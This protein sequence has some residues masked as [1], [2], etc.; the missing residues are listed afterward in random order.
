MHTKHE[1]NFVNTVKIQKAMVMISLRL[2]RIKWYFGETGDK[3]YKRYG[4]TFIRY[5]D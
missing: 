2:L 4:L 3:T 5:L 1:P